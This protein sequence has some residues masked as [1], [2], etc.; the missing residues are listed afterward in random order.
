[1][2]LFLSL[3]LL[4]VIDV[5]DDINKTINTLNN[6]NINKTINYS[7]DSDITSVIVDNEL[8]LHKAYDDFL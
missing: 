4:L 1:M 7:S 3:F 8:S 5:F 6:S 2:N